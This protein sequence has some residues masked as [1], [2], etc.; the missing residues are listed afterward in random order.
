MSP[1]CRDACAAVARAESTAKHACTSLASDGTAIV[2]T[3]VTRD[4]ESTPA[5]TSA[6]GPEPVPCCSHARWYGTTKTVTLICAGMRAPL[7]AAAASQDAV[8]VLDQ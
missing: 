6:S 2:R 3:S 7:R 8:D 4:P 5:E 1:A